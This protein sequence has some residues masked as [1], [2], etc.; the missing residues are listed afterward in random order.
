MTTGNLRAANFISAK[1][2]WPTWLVLVIVYS[3]WI[4]L[5]FY[6]D[7]IPGWLLWLI[8][9]YTIALHSSLQHEALHG[10]PTTSKRIN[11]A[12]VWPPLTLWLPVE[13][14]V[15]NHLR[16]HQAD[17]TDPE[18]DPESFFVTRDKWQKLTRWQQRILVFNNTFLGRMLLGPWLTVG[19]QYRQEFAR[20]L[21][22][23][24][25]H[26]GILLRHVV[27][28][29]VVLYW[30]I[31]VCQIPLW[32][33]LLV[34]AW[35]GTSMMLIRS[36]IEHRYDPD[37]KHRSVLVDGCPITRLLF[38]NN[39][40]HWVHHDHPGLAWY[41]IPAVVRRERDEVL[42][43]NGDYWYTGYLTIAWRFLL[44]PWTHPV[45]PAH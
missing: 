45:Y 4:S 14:Y 42:R 36:F 38:L 12:L 15:K 5:T 22:G 39:N 30:V 17:L 1:I 31:A 3:A 28:V 40:Y 13:L 10:H 6:W 33:Y 32:I 8:G 27:S 2:E 20:L 25:Q 37:E 41:R 9:G 23:D 24:S 18:H 16:H 43:N 21:S 35:P 19:G 11:I 44:K 34:F 7:G 29:A 26:L